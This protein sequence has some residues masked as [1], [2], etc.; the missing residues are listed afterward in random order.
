MCMCVYMVCVLSNLLNMYVPG[1][2][3]LHQNLAE[4]A[5]LYQPKVVAKKDMKSKRAA[6][7]AVENIKIMTQNFVLF[8]Y[9][10]TPAF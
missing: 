8:L 10:L 4:P 9:L 6:T 7:N 5:L 2:S 3:G 1:N